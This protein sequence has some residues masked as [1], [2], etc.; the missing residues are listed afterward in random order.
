[1]T[2]SIRYLPPTI[3][4]RRDEIIRGHD[5]LFVDLLESNRD[6]SR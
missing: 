2:A 6:I 1:M 5:E 4:M 3:A